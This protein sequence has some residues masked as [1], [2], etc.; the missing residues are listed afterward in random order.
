MI[1]VI[2]FDMLLL[3][4]IQAILSFVLS[5]KTINISNDIARKYGNFTVKDFRRYETWEIV[6][7]IFYFF[8]ELGLSKGASIKTCFIGTGAALENLPYDLSDYLSVLEHLVKFRI[9][10][11]SFYWEVARTLHDIVLIICYI[12]GQLFSMPCGVTC[13]KKKMFL[14]MMKR[15]DLDIRF[16]MYV[17]K[18][19]ERY[20]AARTNFRIFYRASYNET[21]WIISYVCCIA[22]L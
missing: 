15:D 16:T 19:T 11:A 5:R 2:L 9:I 22:A 17:Q 18:F 7:R 4:F 20:F 21:L 3:V 13:E 10:W 12:F 14:L 6:K 1:F 8:S